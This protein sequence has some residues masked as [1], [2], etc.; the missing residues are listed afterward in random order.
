MHTNMVYH[1][2]VHQLKPHLVQNQ[3]LSIPYFYAT[4]D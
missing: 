4:K 1:I 2:Q 3:S